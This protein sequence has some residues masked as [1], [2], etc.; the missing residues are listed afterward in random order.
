MTFPHVLEWIS[1]G[2]AGGAAMLVIIFR[3]AWRRG[4]S[5]LEP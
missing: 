4:K 2:S 5:I 3:C 1:Y